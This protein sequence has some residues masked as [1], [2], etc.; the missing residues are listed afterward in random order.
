MEVEDG[1]NQFLSFWSE[2]VF[3]GLGNF[4]DEGMRP[5]E[6]QQPGYPCTLTFPFSRIHE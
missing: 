4:D 5:K 1:R 3:P 6:L 2:T